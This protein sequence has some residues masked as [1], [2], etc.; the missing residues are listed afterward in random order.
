MEIVVNSVACCEKPRGRMDETAN[1]ILIFFNCHGV[2]S[3]LVLQ[4]QYFLGPIYADGNTN[5]FPDRHIHQHNLWTSRE[6]LYAHKHS[7]QQRHLD[8]HPDI[9]AHFHPNKHLDPLFYPSAHQYPD[10]L[11]LQPFGHHY[12]FPGWGRG[13]QPHWAGTG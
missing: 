8:L 5:L 12:L 7:Y 3:C 10:R 1:I 4:L 11:G 2:G 6:H 13:G 9:H